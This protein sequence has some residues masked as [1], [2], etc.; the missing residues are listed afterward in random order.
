MEQAGYRWVNLA[1]TSAGAVVASLLAAGWPAATI[2]GWLQK[3]DLASLSG[4]GSL[5]RL[6]FAN[7]L[8]STSGLEGWLRRQLAQRNVRRFADLVL[9]EFAADPRYRWR[10]QVI[11]TDVS[12]GRLVV[13][14]RDAPQYGLDPDSLEVAR[15]VCCSASIP[16]YYTPGRLGRSVLVDGGVTSNF[17]IWLFDAP[18]EPAWPTFGFRLVGQNPDRRR[19]IA[20]PVSLATAVVAAWL[21]A[22]EE[23]ELAAP[24]AARCIDVPS[25]GVGTT[26]FSLPPA[27]R[28]AL[29]HAGMRA[30]E[31]FLRRWDFT[32]YCRR[33]RGRGTGDGL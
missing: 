26:E 20:G 27:K 28:L 11:V 29:Y 18:G 4:P 6:L 3:L 31:A 30:A 15:T 10:L 1:G 24:H 32:D 2:G 23:R 7:G 25:L 12:R 14:P 5:L 33:F 22:E 17:P 8:H 13:L 21:G 19:I 16:F 9:P